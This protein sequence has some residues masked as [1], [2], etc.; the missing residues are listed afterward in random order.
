MK[1]ETYELI[2]DADAAL[3]DWLH[4]YAPELCKKEHVDV[5]WERI[6]ANG[7]T[8]AYIADLL[9]RL[10]EFLSTEDNMPPILKLTDKQIIELY[11]DVET[12]KGKTYWKFDEQ[13][14]D[15]IHKTVHP[16]E[17]VGEMVRRKLL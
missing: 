15:P 1:K 14:A 4:T 13:Q 8:L 2:R 3:L 16:M 11:N 10:K 12:H 6:M 5:S 9:S 7:G 17:V